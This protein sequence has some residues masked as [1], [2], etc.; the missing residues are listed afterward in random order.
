MPSKLIVSGL[1]L[2]IVASAGHATSHDDVLAASPSDG[3]VIV[4]GSFGTLGRDRKLD[5]SAK[6]AEFCGAD[7]RSCQIFCS[8]TSFG[9]YDLGKKPLCRV[10][11]RCGAE[12]VRS[13]EAMREEPLLLRCPQPQAANVPSPTFDAN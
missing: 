4:S 10:T 7:A 13:V 2:C 11:Y 9:R 3:I 8:E 1:P 6:L 12:Y 5:I